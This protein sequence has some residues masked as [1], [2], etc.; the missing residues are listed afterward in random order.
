MKRLILIL[1]VTLTPLFAQN[2]GKISGRIVDSRSKEPIP[3]ANIVIRGTMYGAASDIEGNYYI[4]NLPPG[5]YDLTASIVGYRSVT[6]TGAIVNINRTT[7]VDFSL[8]ETALQAAEVVVTATRPDVEREKTSTSEIRRGEEVLNVPG[9]QDISDVLTLSSD[10]SDGH[11]RGGRDNEELYNLHGLGIMDPLSGVPAF[12]PIMSAVEEVEV[13]TSGF[14]A[15]YG[16]A[17]SGIVNIT[18]KEGNSERWTA[19][20]ELRTRLPGRKHFGPGLWDPLGNPYLRMLDSPEAWLDSTNQNRDISFLQS[21]FGSDKTAQAQLGYVL[22]H[23]QMHR[24]YGQTYDNLQDYSADV[25]FGGPLSSNARLFM[26]FHLDKIWPW[27]PTPEPNVNRQFMGNLVYD[28]GKGMS[29]RL[30]GAVA[31]N[32]GHTLSGRSSSGWTNWVWD[33]IIP[34]TRTEDNNTQLG[35]R[36]AHALSDRTFYEI[37]LNTLQTRSLV[38]SPITSPDYLQ[39]QGL[40]LPFWVSTWLPDPDGFTSLGRATGT[41]RNDYTRTLSLDASMTSQ[42]TVS[43]MLI[44]GIQGNWYVIDVDDRRNVDS[45]TGGYV[46]SYVAKPFEVGL[47]MQDKMEFEGMI[48]NVGLR[49]DLYNPNA[50]YYKNTFA[51]F[52]YTDSTGS[53]YFEPLAPK[54]RTTTVVRLQPRIG[55]S[56]PVSVSTVFH[57]NYG[58]FLQRPTFSQILSHTFGRL[59]IYNRGGA[60]S[61]PTSQTMGNPRLKPEVTNSYDVG[62]TQGLGE[63]FT[64]DVSGYFKDVKNLVQT[65]QYFPSSS[66]NLPYLSYVNLEYASIRGFRLALAKRKGMLTGTLS[67]TYGVAIGKRSNSDASNYPTI[68]ESGQTNEPLPQDVFLD[69][70]RTHNVI[71]NFAFNTPANWGPEVLGFCPF[72]QMTIAATSFLRSGRPFTSWVNRITPMDKRAPNETTTNIKI[73]KNIPRFFGPNATIYVEISNLFNDRI[74]DYN[75]VFNPDPTNTANLQRFT[76]RY[77]KGEDITYYD[78]QNHPDFLA[79]QEF[80]NFSNAP[81]S[82]TVGMIISF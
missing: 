14:S 79:N 80:R 15:Q 8:D 23:L 76:V 39:R 70:D 32:E 5:S 38:G 41:F 7:T 22:Y 45:R 82:W 34:A 12:N 1:M 9:I 20:G 2:S 24:D 27:L 77:E 53:H 60:T 43:H 55:F 29:L 51:P 6:K 74:Y 58:T 65:A 49:L 4:L 47:Y 48:A 17:Q 16:N 75:A 13:I 37:K 64:L 42:V 63:G 28:F 59:D 10:I 69:F 66:S 30:S 52:Y 31:K 61:V 73:T 3:M 71:G 19:R 44:A 21:L 68:F 78:N 56:F 11:F 26:A 81:R 50:E 25:N 40:Q 36:W 72:D 67:Y 54:E 33:R 46:T 62:V 57:M 18:M 35:L